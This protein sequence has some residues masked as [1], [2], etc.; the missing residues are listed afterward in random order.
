[1]MNVFTDSQ[2]DQ[3]REG[4]ISILEQIGVKVAR[5]DLLQKLESKGFRVDN[6]FVRIERTRAIKHI[7]RFTGNIEMPQPVRPF[8]TFASAYSHTYEKID[9]S[10]FDPVTVG[11]NIAMG[12]FLNHVT[13]LWPGLSPNCPGHP[14]DVHPELQFFRHVINS[15]TWC[16]DY[17]SMEPVSIKVAPYQFEACEAMGRPMTGLPI[18]VASPLNIAGESLDI[19]IANATRL[20]S[21]WVGSMPSLGANTPLNLIAAY[22]QTVAETLGGAIVFEELTGVPT[23]FG[24]SLF[25]FDFYAMSMPFG[26]PEKL[27]LEWMNMEVGARLGGGACKAA[28]AV[29]IH[30]NAV[31]SGM[32]A[33]VEKASLAMAGALKGAQ[34]F[35]CS[36]TL[37]MDEMFSPVQLLIDL[38][39]LNHIE[40]II[41]G[42]P[43]DDFVDDLLEEVGAGI[44]RGYMQTDRTLDNFK[45]YQWHPKFFNRKTFGSYLNAYFP[46]EEQKARDMANDIM[47]RQSNWKLD[48]DIC[49]DL[50]R[51]YKKC[52]SLILNS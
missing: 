27:V 52:E 19:A 51:I 3:I 38:E 20:S 45:R 26:T 37:G 4:A 39:M 17:Y 7:E 33:C 12:Q 5:T 36:G 35:G 40:H 34:S 6:G 15:F 21:A 48:E 22:A 16:E 49:R 31:H 43:V 8:K 47:R 29:D 23:S 41:D 9:Q 1:M 13:K 28:Y 50:E 25:T 44:K 24:T 18:Y 30:T 2:I 32:Q 14:V 11:L 10:G 42:L 46:F